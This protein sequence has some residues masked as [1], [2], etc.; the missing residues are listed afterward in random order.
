MAPLRHTRYVERKKLVFPQNSP[1]CFRTMYDS[2]TL[3]CMAEIFILATAAQSRD[4]FPNHDDVTKLAM[5]I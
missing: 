4:P 1:I 2:H 3:H 5:R